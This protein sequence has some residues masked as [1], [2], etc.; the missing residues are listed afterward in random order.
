MSSTL[1]QRPRVVDEEDFE[2]DERQQRT[3]E[4]MF[5]NI[6]KKNEKRMLPSEIK[7]REAQRL[8]ALKAAE[9]GEEEQKI[10]EK[11]QATDTE[12]DEEDEQDEKVHKVII[13]MLLF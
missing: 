4:R 9:K 1:Q 12:E 5:E 8:A 6:E 2:V 10:S 3:I 13:G 11:S 7:K